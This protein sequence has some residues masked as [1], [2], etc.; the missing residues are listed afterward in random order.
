MILSIAQAA[1]YKSQSIFLLLSLEKFPEFQTLSS[2]SRKL[3]MG[4]RYW[5]TEF[6]LVD[7]EHP[8]PL[9]G[10]EGAR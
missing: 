3:L 7:E 10:T 2:L 5:M 1:A 8:N 9:T 6:R 4:R